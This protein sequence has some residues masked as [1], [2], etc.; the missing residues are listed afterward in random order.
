MSARRA[1]AR[2]AFLVILV[3]VTVSVGLF[4]SAVGGVREAAARVQCANN[5]K[6]LGL[7]VENH[8]AVY[9]HYPPGTVPNTSL[10]PDRRLSVHALLMP[11]IESSRAHGRLVLTDPW[12]ADRNVAALAD[13]PAPV[14]HCP[15]WPNPGPTPGHLLPT[16]YV[17]VAGVGADAAALPADDPRAG[18]VGYDRT[19]TAEQV[20]N[21]L[22]NTALFVETGWDVGLWAR[23][24]PS[25]VRGVDQSDRPL[26]GPGRP[27]GGRHRRDTAFPWQ[28]R[29]HGGNVGLADG[30]VRY[31]R[32]DADPAILAAL[33]TAAG[34]EAGLPGW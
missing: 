34:G 25:T 26:T 13:W 8:R 10:P 23:G 28:D 32:D 20:K 24:G 4:L 16:N 5:L 27:F 29:H 1:G 18:V 15:A 31:L 17:G 7:A 19:L 21:G 12:D 33:A 30:A 11:F 3:V 14:Q 22:A 6:Q 2:V 9:G